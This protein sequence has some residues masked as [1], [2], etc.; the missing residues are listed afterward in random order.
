MSDSKSTEI[1][2]FKTFW[3]GNN[4]RPKVD[5]VRHMFNLQTYRYKKLQEYAL[6]IIQISG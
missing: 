3:R 6:E 2:N 5:N 1:I 4:S